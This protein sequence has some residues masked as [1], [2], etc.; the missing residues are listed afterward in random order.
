[1]S[2]IAEWEFSATFVTEKSDITYAAVSAAN[3]IDITSAAAVMVSV[4]AV[5]A[6]LSML[7]MKMLG[8]GLATAILFDATVIRLV[9]L[10]A[11]LVLLVKLR[12]ELP[13]SERRLVTVA[14]G[15]PVWLAAAWLGQDDSNYVRM[16][17]IAGASAGPAWIASLWAFDHP[18]WRELK[19]LADK[20]LLKLRRGSGSA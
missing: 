14:C 3:E 13:E 8:V 16:L 7:E 11:A 19:G 1:M 4:F 9:I 18:L 5:F 2:G 15:A 20:A 10:P 6:S 17:A 12:R